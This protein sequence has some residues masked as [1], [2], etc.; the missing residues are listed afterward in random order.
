MNCCNSNPEPPKPSCCGGGKGGTT[1]PVH[2]HAPEKLT[3]RLSFNKPIPE[4]P[5]PVSSCCGGGHHH[6]EIST[7]TSEARPGQYTCPMHPEVITDGPDDCPKCGMALEQVT[8]IGGTIYTCPMHPEVQQATPGDCP[9]CGMP[10]EASN[11]GAAAEEHAKREILDLSK[12]F[13]LGLALT[14]PIMALAMLPMLGI[15]TIENLLPRSISKWIELVLAS[16]VVFYIGG[17]FLQKG[18]KS[19]R[20][21]N[22]NMFT[23]IALGVGAAYLYSVVAVIAPGLFPSSFRM[24]GE[25][26]L[27][28]EAAAMITVL[29]MLGQ[30][31]EAKARARTGEA[32]QALLGLAAKSAHRIQEDG[33]EEEVPVESLVIGDRVRVR[34]G[35]KIP[36]DGVLS[37]GSSHID[38]SMITGEPE[39]V[40]KS[41]GDS[42]IGATINQ[43]GS[44]VMTVG[45]TGADTLLSQIIHM[46][47]KAQRS[48]AP[49]QKTADL[50]AAYFVPAVVVAAIVT[51][52]VWAIWGPQPAMTLALVNAVAVLIIACPCALGLATPV[53]IMVGIGRGASEGILIKDA[54]ALEIT[55]KIDTLVI[56]KTGTLTAG[57]PQVTDFIALDSAMEME[58]LAASAAME[59]HSEHPLAR[60]ILLHADGM[61]LPS[62]HDFQST[63][64]GGVSASIHGTPWSIGQ[65]KFLSSNH[66]S[67]HPE[68]LDRADSLQNQAKT[69]VWVSR[70][71]EAV[72]LFAISDPIKESTPRAIRAL[73]DLGIRVVMATGDN[74]HTAKAVATQLGI[75]EVHAALSP[76]DKI[77]LVQRLKSSGRTVAMAGDGINDAPALAQADVGISMGTGT[78]V[79]IESSHVTL[80]KGDLAGITGAIQLSRDVMKNIRQNLFFAFIYNLAGVPVAAGILYPLTGILLNP[81]IAGAAM[82]LSSVSVITNALRLRHGKRRAA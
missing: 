67:T 23:L 25:V 74:E 37:D 3:D 2:S 56:D 49:I 19:V 73:H 59:S 6:G 69:V 35:E 77:A 68:L 16:V 29:V 40:K 36:L 15:H 5:A 82:S 33:Q 32:I 22:L 62:A 46:V 20:T 21:W 70:G 54:E 39:P 14:L 31:L 30:L 63:T 76:A 34:P 28:F 4:I 55:G 26:G 52:I 57:R 64:G 58:I 71:Q 24:H 48:R 79:A 81:M 80:V 47:S 75:D 42:V 65:L 10:L 7:A 78:D 66:I 45:K 27:Y 61:T 72:A 9:K 13:R 17:A 41:T 1:H 12:K 38:E 43:T 60:A 51:F 44:F 8:P 50:V 18:W 53:S 11:P